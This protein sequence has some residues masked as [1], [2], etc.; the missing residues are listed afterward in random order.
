M[1]NNLSERAK[2]FLSE[3][4]YFSADRPF[5]LTLNFSQ[6]TNT[7]LNKPVFVFSEEI[8]LLSQQT[9]TFLN[10][11]IF[12]NEKEKISSADQCISYQ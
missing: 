1:S 8:T 5:I 9:R 10:R 4:E 12:P 6:L 3:P 2:M 7:F 11:Q